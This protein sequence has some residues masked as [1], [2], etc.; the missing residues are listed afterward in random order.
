M[1]ESRRGK[2]NPFHGK[3]HTEENKAILSAAPKNRLTPAV[4]GIQ[5]EITD[6]D[7]NLTTTYDSIRKAA[8]ATNSDIK[9][10]LRR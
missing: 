4:P 9:T 1:S 6:L 5:V 3:T 10:I 8:V 7:T 2:N